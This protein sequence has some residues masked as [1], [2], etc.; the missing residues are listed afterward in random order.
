[1]DIAS[2][3]TDSTRGAADFYYVRGEA[4]LPPEAQGDWLFFVTEGD[5][6]IDDDGPV[7]DYAYDAP[8]FYA[9]EALT[10]RLSSSE[11][12]TDAVSGGFEDTEH[13]KVRVEV[14]D[15]LYLQDDVG[16]VFRIDVDEKPSAARLA[17]R[18]SRI[19]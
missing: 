8:G 11:P 1:M 15:V 16:Q 9:D 6:E 5:V 18:V 19:R 13:E 14:G 12:I 4:D 3:I 17:L 2:E 7:R 10:E